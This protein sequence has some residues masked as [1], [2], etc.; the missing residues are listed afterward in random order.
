MP[1]LK[2]INIADNPETRLIKD[3]FTHKIDFD[4]LGQYRITSLKT[5]K[6]TDV[7]FYDPG[8]ERFDIDWKS[9]VIIADDDNHAHT[10]AIDLVSTSKSKVN[11]E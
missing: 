2:D 3:V 11:N 9:K 6:V 8:D 5:G 4:G 7:Y 1:S 10:M